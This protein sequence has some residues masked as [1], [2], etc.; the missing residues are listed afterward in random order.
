VLRAPD[1]DVASFL[2]TYFL[3]L[4]LHIVRIKI[5]QNYGIATTTIYYILLL[6]LDLYSAIKVA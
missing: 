6:L 3:V 2:I 5:S 4:L 1:I